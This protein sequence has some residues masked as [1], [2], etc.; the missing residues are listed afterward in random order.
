MRVRISRNRRKSGAR[1][2]PETWTLLRLCEFLTYVATPTTSGGPDMG[3]SGRPAGDPGE[4]RSLGEGLH[5]HLRHPCPGCASPEEAGVAPGRGCR[6][7]DSGSR[8]WC[9]RPRTDLICIGWNS[10]VMEVAGSIS[11]HPVAPR[12]PGVRMAVAADVNV[13]AV[14]RTTISLA[15]HK[16]RLRS[17]GKRQWK[18]SRN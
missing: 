14:A 5:H 17:G 18:L 3:P 9:R 16:T 11:G 1:A 8:L 7:P 10:D 6:R 13:M 2:C 15:R 12:A 4:A